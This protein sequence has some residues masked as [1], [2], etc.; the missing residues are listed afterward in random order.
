MKQINWGFIGCGEVTEKKSGPAFNE[1][2]GSQV[3]AVMSRSENKA[4]SYAERHHV[5]KWYTDS[6]ELIEDPD[7]NAVYIATPPSSHATFAI[8]AMRAGKPCYIEKPLAAS[9]NDCIRINRISEQTGVPCFVAYY[10]RYLP[11]FQKVKE[12]IESGTIGNVVNVQV[13]F[14][15]PPRDLDFQSGKEM[16]WRLQPD[17]AGGG[18]FYDLAPHQIDLL[19]NLFGVITRAHGYPAN[20]AHLYQ[21]EDTLSACFFFESGIP[22][23]GSWCF[24]GHESA[25][26]DCIEVI[27]EKGSLSFSVFTYQP[28]EVITSEGKNL[29]TVP[30]PPY[31]QLP[32]IKS[33]IQHL[34]GIGKCDCTSVSATAVNWVL[35]RV[36]WKN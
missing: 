29:I 30:N 27:G 12:I 2:E 36:L 11:Y 21:A 6:S 13:R 32:L 7:V 26:E 18:Y 4:R 17:I 16:P 22:G 14:S 10:R 31:V 8:M 3:V 23:S 1:V 9:Y 24:V 33:V 5:R 15:V 19:Q 35:D 28:I 25:K 34:Q 20:R